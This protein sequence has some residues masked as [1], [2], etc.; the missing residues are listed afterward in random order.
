MHRGKKLD[1]PSQGALAG[2][3]SGVRDDYLALV[4]GKRIKHPRG[5]KV[6]PEKRAKLQEPSAKQTMSS[7]KPV[8]QKQE[9]EEAKKNSRGELAE[10]R[11]SKHE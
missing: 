9:K 10:K 4:A 1:K 3:S 6:Q 7:T 2:S 8:V 11:Q 5:A